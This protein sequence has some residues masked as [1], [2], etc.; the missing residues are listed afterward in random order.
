MKGFIEFALKH[1]KD[2]DNEYVLNMVCSESSRTGTKLTSIETTADSIYARYNVERVYGS[3]SVKFSRDG[4]EVGIVSPRQVSIIGKFIVV[5]NA[6]FL[7]VFDI[8]LCENQSELERL[9]VQAPL[10]A[11][12]ICAD[13]LTITCFAPHNRFIDPRKQ[14]CIDANNLSFG[15]ALRLKTQVELAYVYALFCRQQP[16]RHIVETLGLALEPH[17]SN[18]VLATYSVNINRLTCLN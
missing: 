14:Y 17:S 5:N 12:I 2:S 9:F 18:R 16:S 11:H 8:T 10:K 6:G 13:D 7:Q 4:E 3:D 1:A 15:Q